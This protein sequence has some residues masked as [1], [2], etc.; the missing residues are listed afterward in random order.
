MD[1]PNRQ[2]LAQLWAEHWSAPFPPRC[3]GVDIE[4]VEL[5]LVDADVA[6][7]VSVALSRA[8]DDWRRRVLTK[9]IGDLERI[10][11]HFEDEYE[12]EYF[13]RLHDMALALAALEGVEMKPR[14]SP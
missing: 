9:C 1:D 14:P 2:L 11:P 4:N 3:R 7:C 6:A 12:V 5:V 13:G 8:L 10:M